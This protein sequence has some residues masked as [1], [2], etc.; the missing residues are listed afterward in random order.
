[1]QTIVFD[2]DGTLLNSKRRHQGVLYD[3]ISEFCGSTPNLIL[4]DFVEYKANGYSTR[5]YLQ[6]K[7]K[8]SLH[9]AGSITEYWKLYIEKPGYLKQDVLYDDSI[10]TLDLLFGNYYLVLLSARQN[11]DMLY[12]QLVKFGVDKYF[13]NIIC[14]DPLKAISEKKVSMEKKPDII[15]YVGDTEVDYEAAGKIPFFALNRGFRNKNYW[16]LRR[17]NSFNN[18]SYLPEVI[19]KISGGT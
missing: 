11:K 3:A 15:L 2:F 13:E 10:S 4:D 8:F 12:Q 7:L 16:D 9:D 17:I 18:L 19:K 6:N 1:V 14:V 5:D